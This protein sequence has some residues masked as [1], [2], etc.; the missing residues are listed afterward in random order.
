MLAVLNNLSNE[1][2]VATKQT[3]QQANGKQQQ[4]NVGSRAAGKLAFYRCLLRMKIRPCCNKT[5]RI[6][7]AKELVAV[8]LQQLI[9][10]HFQISKFLFDPVHIPRFQAS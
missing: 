8:Y 9:L 7:K 3:Q 5:E 4:I 6:E 2:L 1:L 10:L